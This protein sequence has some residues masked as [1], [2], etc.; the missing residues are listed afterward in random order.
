MGEWQERAACAGEDP[1]LWHPNDSRQAAQAKRICKQ[2]P[3]ILECLNWA[4]NTEL[5]S[6]REGIY[7]GTTPNE[8]QMIYKRRQ[9][10]ARQ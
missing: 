8:R 1:E 3:V 5:P 10:R 9:K 4:L 2:C 7:G 6:T